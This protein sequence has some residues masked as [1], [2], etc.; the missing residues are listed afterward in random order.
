[1]SRD[2]WLPPGVT[3]KDIDDAV[4]DIGVARKHRAGLLQEYDNSLDHFAEAFEAGWREVW[5]DVCR[6]KGLT[7]PFEEW[8]YATDENGDCPFEIAG[9]WFR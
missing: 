9:G 6:E 1:M 4:V 8:F 5:R 7:I 3:Y 2:G